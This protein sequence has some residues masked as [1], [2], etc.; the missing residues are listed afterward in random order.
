MLALTLEIT[1][2]FFLQTRNICVRQEQAFDWPLE[3]Y[4]EILFCTDFR[5]SSEVCICQKIMSIRKFV[6]FTSSFAQTTM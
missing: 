4:L 3:S 6:I 1:E 5:S 2:N